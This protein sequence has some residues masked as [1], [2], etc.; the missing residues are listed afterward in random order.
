MKHILV[1]DDD[2]HIGNLL[3][4]A[5]EAEGYR[6]SRA[7]SGTE[8]VLALDR[9]RP[10]LALLDLMLPGLSG[11]EVLPRLAGI[12][13]IVV[14]AKA[15]IDSKTSLL[16]GGAADYV[17]KPFVLRELLARV[18]VRLRE[19]C[20]QEAPA[21]GDGALAFQNLWLEP[22]TRSVRIDGE[23]VHLTRTEYAILK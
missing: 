10:D 18:A 20:L 16:L 6:V 9:E 8:A 22:E 13:V 1:I 5:L 12:P 11:E 23:E 2:I 21:R 4:E 19:A 7:Y 15:D 3:Q 14:S 17:T